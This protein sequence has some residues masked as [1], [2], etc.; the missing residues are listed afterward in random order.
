MK[1]R[2]RFLA[3]AVATAATITTLTACGP[4]AELTQARTAYEAAVADWDTAQTAFNSAIDE[5][6]AA[7]GGA[8]DARAAGSA[9]LDE[10]TTVLD[11]ASSDFNSI[12]LESTVDVAGP[13]K[14][15]IEQET[16]GITEGDDAY[17]PQSP[18]VPTTKPTLGEE[19][20]EGYEMAAQSLVGDVDA[21][22]SATES[23][24]GESRNIVSFVKT[25]TESD[26]AAAYLADA[27]TVVETIREVVAE[28]VQ[29]KRAASITDA[30]TAAADALQAAIDSG[31]V[32]AQDLITAIAAANN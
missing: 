26:A 11:A 12:R 4:S 3:I 1:T 10:I 9:T 20:V 19:S 29:R 25:M 30:Q 15:L 2:T 16:L 18:E 17:V 32:T 24:V 27:P 22:T 23:I 5:R 7:L 6:D 28:G 31:N 21:F 14:E 13:L 8:A